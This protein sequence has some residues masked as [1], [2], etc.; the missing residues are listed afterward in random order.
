MMEIL[1]VVVIIGIMAIIFGNA[2][3]QAAFERQRGQEAISNLELIHNG[4]K[5]F[6]LE[7]NN[8]FFCGGPVCTPEEIRSNLT[9]VIDTR[10]F[11][12]SINSTTVASQP[13]YRAVATRRSGECVGRS[14]NITHNN[15]T[16]QKGCDKW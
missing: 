12:Y 11:E 5:R 9:F 4:E 16:I 14:L 2:G 15:S 6:F 3:N 8:Y 7:H 1:I 13:G 10:N